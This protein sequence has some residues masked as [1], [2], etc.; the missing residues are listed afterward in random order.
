MGVGSRRKMRKCQKR[1]ELFW[2]TL[3]LTLGP[4]APSC[5][6]GVLCIC[7]SLLLL[8][9]FEEESLLRQRLMAIHN[10]VIMEVLQRFTKGKS[11]ICRLKQPEIC[12]VKKMTSQQH[13][14]RTTF[15]FTHQHTHTDTQTETTMAVQRR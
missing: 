1:K 12:I 11:H 15:T 13:E 8:E 4:I 9:P 2:T 3:K 7:S 5:L 6:L 10:K 14:F